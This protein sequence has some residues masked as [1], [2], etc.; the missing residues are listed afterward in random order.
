[1]LFRST[2]RPPRSTRLNTLFPYTTLFR[3]TLRYADQ[4]K[5]IRTRAVV[6]QDSVSAAERDAQIAAMA[7]EIRSLQLVVGDT[8]RRERDAR[9]ADEERLDEYQARVRG[10]Q[11]LMEERGLM[12]ESK[13]R[14]LQT[15]NEALRLHLKLALDSLRDPIPALKVVE[16]EAAPPGRGDDKGPE[17]LVHEGGLSE[18]DDDDENDDDDDD[19]D[20]GYA[21]GDGGPLGLGVGPND[22]H[23]HMDGLL[24]DLDLFRKKIGD[25]KSRFVISSSA[26]TGLAPDDGGGVLA[27]FLTRSRMPLG[28]RTNII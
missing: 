2:R 22:M 10:L 27:E 18:D 17:V 1:M 5:R 28:T 19:D 3:S 23:D 21:S 16:V 4:A 6:N 25:D 7:A 8:R 26:T 13:I 11:R 9:E 12:A 24:R 15:E 14:S 20:D